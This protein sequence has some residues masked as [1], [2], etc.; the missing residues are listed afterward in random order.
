MSR[1][2][3]VHV[4]MTHMYDSYDSYD[5]DE[6]DQ[7]GHYNYNSLISLTL[8]VNCPK[9]FPSPT[10]RPND[11]PSGV[12]RLKQNIYHEGVRESHPLCKLA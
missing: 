12:E 11:F 4:C 1:M 10:V 9:A 5:Y 3:L 7:A 8:S 6:V 2:T